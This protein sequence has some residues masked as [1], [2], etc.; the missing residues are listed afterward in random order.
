[1]SYYL[2]EKI[3]NFYMLNQLD[4][5]YTRHTNLLVTQFS[6]KVSSIKK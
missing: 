3:F 6:V 2:R 4:S 1:M 5:R